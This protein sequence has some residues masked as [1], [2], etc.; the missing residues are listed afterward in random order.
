M[1]TRIRSGSHC[2]VVLTVLWATVMGFLLVTGA[3]CLAAQ[4]PIIRV[5]VARGEVT[6]TGTGSPQVIDRVGDVRPGAWVEPAAG[7]VTY[8]IRESG[9][10]LLPAGIRTRVAVVPSNWATTSEKR[11]LVELVVALFLPKEGWSS[12]AI[13]KGNEEGKAAQ[14]RV[15]YPRDTKVEDPEPVFAWAGGSDRFEVRLY[16]SGTDEWLWK[17]EVRGERRVPIS[18]HHLEDGQAYA[19]EVRDIRNPENVAIAVFETPSRSERRRIDDAILKVRESCRTTPPSF[20]CELAVAGLYRKEGYVYNAIRALEVIR[21]GG[22][23]EAIVE[24]LLRELED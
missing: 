3:D 16:R 17:K 10:E 18:G 14:F 5:V 20:T 2:N 21:S 8:L 9:V 12:P 6:V 13:T 4:D 22:Q 7:S 19:W 23:H 11:G 1:S 24:G 15:L